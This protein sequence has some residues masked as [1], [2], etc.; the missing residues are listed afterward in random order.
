MCVCAHTIPIC[1]WR[2]YWQGAGCDCDALV[3]HIRDSLQPASK[4]PGS[5]CPASLLFNPAQQRLLFCETGRQEQESTAAW[6]SMTCRV[7]EAG[8]VGQGFCSCCAL[9]AVCSAALWLHGVNWCAQADPEQSKIVQR[10]SLG[11]LLWHLVMKTV[12]SQTAQ[13]GRERS[14]TYMCF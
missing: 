2:M 5:Q 9:C 7:M 11:S 13:L 14:R 12:H 4:T 6:Y 10:R 1:E 3:L 8:C